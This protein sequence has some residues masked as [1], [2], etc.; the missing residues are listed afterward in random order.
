MDNLTSKKL[1]TL[2]SAIDHLLAEKG[3]IVMAIDGPCTAG[4]T[5]L[6]EI[7]RKRY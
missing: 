5:T 4:K 7:L 2:F 1:D 6:S 3:R